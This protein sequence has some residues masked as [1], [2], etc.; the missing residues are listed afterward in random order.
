MIARTFE[1]VGKE[2]ID[3]QSFNHIISG[4]V[5]YLIVFFITNIFF[6]PINIWVRGWICFI[7]LFCGIMWEIIENV[8]M[9]EA[10]FRIWGLDSLE[11][12]LMDIFFD[13]I[14]VII[15]CILSFFGWEVMLISGFI[16]I[17]VLV[18]LMYIFMKL[19]KPNNS[20]N[21]K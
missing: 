18:F 6:N 17:L 3:F 20:K 21:G 10:F 2:P 1:E 9:P 19:T 7:A 4:F 14:G 16:I 8:G 11:N 13:F 12:S 15:A 5:C